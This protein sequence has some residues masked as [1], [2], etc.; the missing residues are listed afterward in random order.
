[1]DRTMHSQVSYPVCLRRLMC[2]LALTWHMVL[3]QASFGAQPGRQPL[4]RDSS[5]S[6][7]D[8]L[9]GQRQHFSFGVRSERQKMSWTGMEGRGGRASDAASASVLGREHSEQMSVGSESTSFPRSGGET[10]TFAA[11]TSNLRGGNVES[12][13]GSSRGGGEE[14]ERRHQQEMIKVHSLWRQVASARPG[15]CA[16]HELRDARK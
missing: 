16:G 3:Q 15:D 4:H 14:S 8:L 11:S 5:G 7:R 12:E 10:N 1:M 2:F 6:A 9:R 13:R